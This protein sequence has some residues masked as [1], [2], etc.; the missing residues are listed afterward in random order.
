MNFVENITDW[1]SEQSLASKL[2]LLIGII[3][4]ISG[5]YWYF[6]WSPNNETLTRLNK[7]LTQKKARLAVLENIT[8]ELPK[9]EKEFKRLNKEFK[10]A[11]YKLPREQEIPALIDSI[12]SEVSAS[13]LEP[14]IFSK[15][16]EVKKEL[17]AEIPIKMKVVGSFYEVTTFFDKVSRLPRIVNIRNINLKKHKRSNQRN[18][19]LDADFTAVTFRLL[20]PPEPKKNLKK[21]GKKKV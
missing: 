10:V 19:V 11:S 21:K 8:K 4:L 16:G 2:M 3:I 9:F 15:K 14:I 1:L 13:G 20:P 18:I 6:F 17:Y 5:L 12:Y 7:N